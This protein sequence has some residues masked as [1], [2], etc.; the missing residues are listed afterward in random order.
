[1]GFENNLLAPAFKKTMIQVI[2]LVF[3]FPRDLV[4]GVEE[5]GLDQV[6]PPT[7]EIEEALDGLG[8]NR[9]SSQVG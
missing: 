6:G 5:E 4:N 8:L 1:M 9:I 7:S 3:E 2:L